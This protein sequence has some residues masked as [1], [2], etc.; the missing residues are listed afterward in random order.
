[1]SAASQSKKV[2]V[3][4]ADDMADTREN[5]TKLL[6]FEKDIEVVGGASDGPQAVEMSRKLSPDIVL[7]DVNMPGLDGI[8]AAAAIRESGCGSA[9]IMMSVQDDTQLYRQAML[10]GAREFLTKPFSGQDLIQSIRRVY[11]H[12]ERPLAGR[13]APITTATP[14]LPA[15]NGKIITV[16]SPKGGVGR[17]TLAVNLSVALR[18]L[19]DATVALVDG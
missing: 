11:E 7:L 18:K 8:A 13:P 2:T 12:S 5:L 16:F 1:M 19:T 4:I 17:T 9:V 15:R 3:L 10:A 6:Y 14:V